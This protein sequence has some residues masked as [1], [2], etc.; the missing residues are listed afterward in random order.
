MHGLSKDNIIQAIYQV[1][2]TE[3]DHR[4]VDLGLIRD[5]YYD[6]ETDEAHITLVVPEGLVS[7]Q[8]QAQMVAGLQVAMDALQTALTV[9]VQPM[10][11]HERRHYEAM[12]GATAGAD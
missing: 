12:M 4:L 3:Q 9:S 10:E 8:E 5:I 2:H 11:P 6:T 1:R 7:K